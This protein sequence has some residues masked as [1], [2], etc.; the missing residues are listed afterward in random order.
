MILGS[1]ELVTA[2]YV[3]PFFFKK[4]LAFTTLFYNSHPPF[5]SVTKARIKAHE[6]GRVEL[7][8]LDSMSN[9]INLMMYC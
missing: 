9:L 3:F 6:H 4:G 7:L 1:Q 8:R 5:L 2:G